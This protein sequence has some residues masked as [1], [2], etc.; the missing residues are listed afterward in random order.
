[1]E[2]KNYIKWGIIG[3]VALFI[4]GFGGYRTLGWYYFN[5]GSEELQNNN[6][7]NAQK[8][9]NRS[10]IFNSHNPATFALLGKTALG[11][12]S[13]EDPENYYPNANYQKAIEYYEKAL[14]NGI[15]KADKVLYKH[16]LEAIGL[17]FWKEGN[18]NKAEEKYLEEIKNFPEN[19][20]WARYFV[21]LYYFEHKNKPEEGLA[22]LREA[23]KMKDRNL[24]FVYR[25]YTLLGR[26]FL[27]KKDFENTKITAN[28]ALENAPSTDKSLDAQLPHVLLAQVYA[29]QGNLK[30]AEVEIAK[31]DELA[32]SKIHT[33]SLATAYSYAKQF[34][35]SIQTAKLVTP[36]DSYGYSVC[37]KNLAENSKV[38]GKTTDAKKYFKDYLDLTEKLPAKNI[39]VMAERERAQQELK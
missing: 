21:G 24:L 13:V 38:L 37:L 31:A 32:G 35:K 3:I 25:V 4:L 20:F 36:S 2:N 29:D 18:Y 7:D 10:L 5:R 17:S 19:S 8:Y 1:M 26:Y 12:V 23:P 22:I 33:C 16:T 14:S 15:D 11:K 39:F 34:E 9:L 28:L 27:F 30:S 6:F